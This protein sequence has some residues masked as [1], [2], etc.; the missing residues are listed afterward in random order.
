MSEVT[1]AVTYAVNTLV[2]TQSVQ[3]GRRREQ[4][5]KQEGDADTDKDCDIFTVASLRQMAGGDSA[6]PAPSAWQLVAMPSN[7]DSLQPE[8][9]SSLWLPETTSWKPSTAS[10]RDSLQ[11]S[12]IASPPTLFTVEQVIWPGPPVGSIRLEKEKDS[13]A[14]PAFYRNETRGVYTRGG[15]GGRG[16]RSAS[17][18]SSPA[19]PYSRKRPKRD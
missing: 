5:S 15:G 10:G 19:S 2:L 18:L 3:E 13:M 17:H 12:A 4:Q 7:T 11:G 8:D 9:W 14:V 16:R 1:Y 6:L